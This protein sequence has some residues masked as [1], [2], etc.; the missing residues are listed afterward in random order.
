MCDD[1]AVNVAVGPPMPLVGS[2]SGAAACL[3]GIIRPNEC[4]RERAL[5]SGKTSDAI[6]L[7]SC[8]GEFFCGGGECGGFVVVPAGDQ[9]VVQA[10]EQAAE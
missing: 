7:S 4:V 5:H 1:V 2:G 10:A 9:A 3:A 6:K 8:A